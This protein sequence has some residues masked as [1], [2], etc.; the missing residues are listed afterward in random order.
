MTVNSAPWFIALRGER[1]GWVQERYDDASQ[2]LQPENFAWLS[3]LE[4]K[5]RVRSTVS[6]GQ[7]KTTHLPTRSFS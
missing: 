2:Y 7:N 6:Q 5:E 4:T 1:Y 3:A